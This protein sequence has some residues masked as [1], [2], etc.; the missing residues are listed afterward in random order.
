VYEGL[1]YGRIVATATSTLWP[2][3]LAVNE[4]LWR[5][6]MPS[7]EV[8]L[9]TDLLTMWV[10]CQPCDIGR[11]KRWSMNLLLFVRLLTALPVMV[12]R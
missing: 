8:L 1:V 6:V 2:V 11:W 9:A 7:G 5:L 10:G 4:L 12:K 3:A